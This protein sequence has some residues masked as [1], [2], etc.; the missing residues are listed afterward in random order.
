MEPCCKAR[1]EPARCSRREASSRAAAS[2][3][4]AGSRR[5][6][7]SGAG[8]QRVAVRK[9]PRGYGADRGSPRAGAAAAAG[10]SP[11]GA[12]QPDRSHTIAR[13]LRQCG[14]GAR[15]RCGPDRDTGA[16]AAARSD[17]DR[18]PGRSTGGG[19]HAGP[20]DACAGLRNRSAGGDHRSG[21][22]YITDRASRPRLPGCYA[23]SLASLNAHR[24]Y[25]GL[26]T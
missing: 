26:Q 4:A 5:R 12:T 22:G 10:S 14:D 13:R 3:A 15:R 19:H 2:A 9:E 18:C 6:S 20:G 23:S 11:A 17:G 8:R 24:N 16:S 7:P 25:C 1:H 21:A